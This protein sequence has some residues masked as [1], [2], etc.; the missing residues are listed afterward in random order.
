MKSDPAAAAAA[1]G[2]RR[3]TLIT[4]G[5]A[6][7]AVDRW[8]FLA[9]GDVVRHSEVVDSLER[10][11]GVAAAAGFRLPNVVEPRL[12]AEFSTPLWCGCGSVKLRGGLH[13][14]S[15]GTLRYEGSEEAAARTFSP[16]AWTTVATLG[17]SLFAEYDGHGIRLDLDSR[18]VI[19]GPDLSFGI[20]W[21]F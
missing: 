20:V 4:A 11:V 6:W 14:R 16:G 5:F 2:V 12:G 3:P 19:D 10:N 7:R 13:Y 8:T 21:R 17:V 18:D 1:I 9:Q 15:P